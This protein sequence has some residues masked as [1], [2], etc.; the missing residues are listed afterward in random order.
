[1][2]TS[3]N[4][5]VTVGATVVIESLEITDPQIVAALQV[6]QSENRDLPEY[7]TT[8]VEIGVK[9]IVSTGVMIGIDDL[10]DGIKTATSTMVNAASR[11]STEIQEK[12][13]AV[14]GENGVLDERFT[15]RIEEFTSDLERLTAGDASPIQ[16]GIKSQM[17]DMAKKLMDDFARE[18]KRQST[19][20]HELFTNQFELINDG[21]QGVLEEIQKNA[22]VSKV[23]DT[24][25][26]KGLSYEDQVIETV[27]RIAGLAGDECEATGHQVGLLPRRVAG[28]G[29][30]S[31][32]PNGDKVKARI[33]VE[34]KNS[35]L[36]KKDWLKEIEVGKANRDASGFIGF[37]KNINDMPNKN[38]VM[39]FDRQTILV[40][41]DPETEDPQIALIIYQ[42]VKMN[43]LATAGHLDDTR[44]SEIN[45]SVDQALAALRMFDSLTKDA[46][47][48]ERLGKKMVIDAT[49]LKNE[50][51]NNLEAIQASISLD[52][53]ALE[54]EPQATLELT[55]WEE[56]GF[57]DD[58]E[59]GINL[60]RPEQVA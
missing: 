35:K 59:L 19:E 43:T 27:Q 6:A 28:D 32:R 34:T 42:L 57:V 33:V 22:I 56:D 5:N 16:A 9:A 31:L 60:D 30:V 8:A 11:L 55:A 36:S 3:K 38:R 12:I 40:A 10:T 48:V 4:G 20:I 17:T 29:V 24:T 15:K 47:S 21:V 49:A 41:Y 52:L 1:M 18:T 13:Q 2:K 51:A 50:I 46:R 7:M 54:L 26:Q 44:I 25:P 14:T 39:I 45:E 58:E 53:D 23:I 37:C